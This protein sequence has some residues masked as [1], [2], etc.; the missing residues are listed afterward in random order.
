MLGFLVIGVVYA[1]TAVAQPGP[2]QTYIVS[3]AIASGWR[4]TW[5][6]AFAPLLSDGPIAVL[7]LFVL[8]QVPKVLVSVLQLGGGLFLLYLALGAF[9]AWRHFEA[10]SQGEGPSG[11]QGLLKAAFINLLNPNPYIGW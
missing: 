6:A 1:F 4:K 9:R 10:R 8:A 5:P 7:V 3:Q 11:A 2:Y